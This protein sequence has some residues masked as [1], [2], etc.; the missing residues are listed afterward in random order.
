MSFPGCACGSKTFE[1]SLYNLHTYIGRRLGIYCMKP[2]TPDSQKLQAE[3]PWSHFKPG[4]ATTL[5]D[6]SCMICEEKAS[7]RK[8]SN[9]NP[10]MIS[11]PRLSTSFRAKIC[12]FIA[13]CTLFPPCIPLFCVTPGSQARSLLH[14]ATIQKHNISTSIPSHWTTFGCEIHVS[15]VAKVPELKTTI[16]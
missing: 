4:C 14:L 13:S 5:P 6:I 12:T 9:F 3:N 8:D 7:E 10:R 2:S 16:S 1:Y 15:V 11:F